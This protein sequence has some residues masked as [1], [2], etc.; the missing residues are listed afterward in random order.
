MTF[1]DVDRL[2]NYELGLWGQ[3][4]DRWCCEGMPEDAVYLTW[5][6]GEPYF[7][8]DRRTFAPINVGMIPQFETETI[9]ETERYIVFRHAN[10]IITKALKEGTVRG[11]RPSMDQ[12]LSFP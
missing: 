11:T 7:G 2:P 5:F 8:I 4:V 12:Y 10:G 1:Q 9:E 3:T 6:E